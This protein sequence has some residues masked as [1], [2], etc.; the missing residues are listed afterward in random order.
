MAEGKERA[1]EIL[2][3]PEGER[4]WLTLVDYSVKYA[5]RFG[6]RS[7]K[8]LPKGFSPE[9][10][11][12]DVLIK[13]LEGKR[14]WDEAK[15]P[16]LLNALKG[17]VQSDLSHL[18]DDYEGTHIEPTDRDLPDGPQLTAD[19]FPGQGLNPEEETLQ[20]ERN[21][22][23]ATALDLIRA[24]VEGNLELESVF[25][26]LYDSDKPKEIARLTGIC[27]ERVYSLCRELERI[28]AKITPSRVA[29]EAKERR[30]HE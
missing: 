15:E 25:L 21:R 20:S 2:R 10:I 11:A 3:G 6:W 4:I 12:K 29:R 19:S 13:V 18:F 16:I 5:R 28:A 1:A 7:D 24:E 22:L 14:V 17:M 23:E 26:A 27:A 8:T 30:K 9:E